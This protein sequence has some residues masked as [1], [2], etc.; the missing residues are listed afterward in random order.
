[1][2]KHSTAIVRKT[3]NSLKYVTIF[4]LFST[5]SHQIQINEYWLISKHKQAPD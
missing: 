4:F 3:V 2:Y 1:M 5:P